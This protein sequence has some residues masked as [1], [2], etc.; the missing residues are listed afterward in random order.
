[1]KIEGTIALLQW[2]RDRT[3]NWLHTIA[4][5]QWDR[6]TKNWM[7]IL[8]IGKWIRRE[9]DVPVVFD[10]SDQ[11]EMSNVGET[12]WVSEMDLMHQNN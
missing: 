9:N 11:R 6:E 5:K 1:M 12:Q 4:V 10:F 2:L 7:I 8:R 3:E